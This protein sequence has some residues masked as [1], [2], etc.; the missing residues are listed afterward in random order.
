MGRVA[1]LRNSRIPG[2]ISLDLDEPRWK[3]MT[4]VL[5]KAMLRTMEIEAEAAERVGK[6]DKRFRATLGIISFESPAD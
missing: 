6:R 2:K 1:I 3:E 4:D 5:D